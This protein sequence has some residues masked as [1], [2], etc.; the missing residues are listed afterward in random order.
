MTIPTARAV[1]RP[2]QPPPEPVMA[3]RTS[4]T[5]AGMRRLDPGELSRTISVVWRADEARPAVAA[6]R[7][8]PRE[9]VGRPAAC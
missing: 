2:P 4:A 9:A 7:A 5:P 6:F 1:P 8:P 3:S